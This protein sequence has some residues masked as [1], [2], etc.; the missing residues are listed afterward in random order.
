[1]INL[2]RLYSMAQT[3]KLNSEIIARYHF[4]RKNGGYIV[5]EN[6]LGA[7]RQARRV[8]Q[9]QQLGITVSWDSDDCFTIGDQGD[10]ISDEEFEKGLNSGRYEVRVLRAELNDRVINSLGGIITDFRC[11][12]WREQELMFEYEI[13]AD[14]FRNYYRG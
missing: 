4:I 10:F 13:L 3:P 5:G 11:K 8:Y 6:A 14:A 9:A 1:M 7:I 2:Y 12:D